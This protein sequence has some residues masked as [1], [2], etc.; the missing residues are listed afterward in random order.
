MGVKVI[1][2]YITPSCIALFTFQL[3]ANIQTD[4]NRMKGIGYR[5]YKINF[6]L[7]EKKSREFA[8]PVR[9]TGLQLVF[10]TYYNF[11]RLFMFTE[12]W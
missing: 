8:F 9:R 6:Q 4:G 7:V 11:L 10:I 2:S 1:R 3:S 12:S 5:V